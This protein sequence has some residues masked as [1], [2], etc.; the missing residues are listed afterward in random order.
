MS[1]FES[2]FL[3]YSFTFGMSTMEGR[4]FYYPTDVVLGKNGRVY[5]PNRSIPVVVRGV[6]ITVCDVDGG[7][8]GTFGF[9]GEEDGQFMWPCAGAVDSSGL[10]YFSDEYTHRI[11]VFD[12]E[13]EFIRKWGTQGSAE[14]DL[15]TPS[16]VAFDREDNLYVSDTYN[17]R[18]Q[19]YTNDG[20]FLTSF[21]LAG[22]KPGQLNH[23]WG[24]T[25][26]DK[27]FIY[28]ADW[29][30]DRIQKFSSEGQFLASYGTS[31]RGD[32]QFHRP[33]GVA[34]DG[35]GY[36]YVSDW[37]NQR[38]QVIDPE[39]GFVAKLRGQATL[40]VWA[41]N[42]LS[43]N[44]EEANARSRANLEP[45]IEFFNDDPHEESSHIEKYFWSPVSVKLDGAG[46]LY[47]TDSNRHRVQVYRRNN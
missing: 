32:G 37:G 12:A 16:G 6:R 35:D 23:P 36:I 13:G 44:E 28:V 43:V 7:Y 18:V 39:G 10:L 46:N 22:S 24:L 5:V 2:S 21:G 41:E 3:K 29:G 45:D 40:S 26:T 1:T 38:V 25:V 31:G 17:N 34:V 47:V 4:G 19:K 20:K 27:G 9:R 8:Y 15:D 33:S 30:N 42:F 11:S 14:G